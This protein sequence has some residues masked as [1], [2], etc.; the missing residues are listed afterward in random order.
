MTK[1]SFKPWERVISD[2]R[3]VPKNGHVD[4]I[5]HDSDHFE[6]TMGREHVLRFIT[7][8]NEQCS[9]CTAALRD[10]PSS[11]GLANSLDDHCV[12]GSSISRGA[13]YVAPNSIPK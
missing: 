9:S 11:S 5:Q 1:L 12:C 13:R 2:V 4:D 7:C 8:S 6:A 10:L 3:L